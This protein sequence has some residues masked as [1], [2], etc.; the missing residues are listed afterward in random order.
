MG[1]TKRQ[2]GLALGLLALLMST[3]AFAQSDTPGEQVRLLVVDQ[4]KTFLSTMRI[5]GLVGA[6]KG[7]GLYAVDVTFA[8]A[9]SDWDD[10]LAGQALAEGADPYDVVL[11]IPRGIDDGSAD[12]VWILSQPASM[13]PPEVAMGLGVL[14]E[15]LG[16]VFEGAMD[17]MNSADD[18]YL[19]FLHS[20]Y[21]SEGWMR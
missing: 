4:T 9:A 2:M 18:L 8:D 12:W 13:A 16:L 17:P 14:G 1:M 15:V 5:G 20:L 3:A 6:L 7:T 19:A 10:P 11:I 21:I